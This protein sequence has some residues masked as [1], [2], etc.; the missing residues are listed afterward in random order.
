[1]MTRLMIAARENVR[2]S[3]AQTMPMVKK[4]IVFS[5]GFF[6]VSQANSTIP[7]AVA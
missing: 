2:K 4:S 6:V 3:A 5:N 7:N 1:M